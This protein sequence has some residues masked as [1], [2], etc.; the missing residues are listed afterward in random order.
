MRKKKKK[1]E[2]EN[3]IKHR[4]CLSSV[5]YRTRKLELPFVCALASTTI[6]ASAEGLVKMIGSE[7][8]S[9]G[10]DRLSRG[11]IVGANCSQ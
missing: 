9:H 2:E 4:R 10:Q 1:E 11:A 3:K 7:Q 5:V 8:D 6:W